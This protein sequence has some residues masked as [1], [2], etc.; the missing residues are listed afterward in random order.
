MDRAQRALRR[1]GGG[2][3]WLT[4]VGQAV[5]RVSGG[6]DAAAEDVSLPRGH[7]QVGEEL[8]VQPS[9]RVDLS[10]G[11]PRGHW[12]P[13]PGPGDL[14]GGWEEVGHR[15]DQ[16]VGLPQ[17]QGVAREDVHLRDTCGGGGGSRRAAEALGLQGSHP[18]G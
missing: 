13:V 4:P 3:K 10:G 9:D 15:A 6:P 2:R 17:L 12:L 5:V 11:H 16:G 14:G 1:E 8:K 18:T 7:L